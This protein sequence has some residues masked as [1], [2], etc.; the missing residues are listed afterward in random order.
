[1]MSEENQVVDALNNNKDIQLLNN[2]KIIQSQTNI[3][4]ALLVERTYMECEND[5]TNTILTLLKKL[6]KTTHKEPTDIDIF[7]QILDEKDKIYHEV[8]ERNKQ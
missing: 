5:V 8:M 7:R 3:D 4:D 6:P 2:I 1:M